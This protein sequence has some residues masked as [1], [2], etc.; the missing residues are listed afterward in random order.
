MSGPL[1]RPLDE[2]TPTPSAQSN[3]VSGT[4]L[5]RLRRAAQNPH[6][7]EDPKEPVSIGVANPYGRGLKAYEPNTVWFTDIYSSIK[8]DVDAK[9]EAEKQQKLEVFDFSQVG[10][11]G[12]GIADADGQVGKMVTAAMDLARRNVP[13][14]WGGTSS[15]GVDCSGLIYYA[16]QAAGIKWQRYRAVDYGTMGQ[17]ISLDAARPGDIIYY[18]NPGD[19]DHVGIYIGNG[20]MIQAPQS[21]DH[22]R[23]TGVGNYTSIRRVFNDNAYAAGFTNTGG[24][25]PMYAGRPYNPIGDAAVSHAAD[26][27]RGVQQALGGAIRPTTTQSQ[28]FGGR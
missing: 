27:F 16:A 15:N 24:T 8:G 21:G 28:F 10:F 12:G 25:Q 11:Q 17:S 9:N 2:P 26:V 6:Q 22:V 18:D 19:V 3:I 7:S 4:A 14:V 23:V 13:Y 1:F 5:S 20:Q